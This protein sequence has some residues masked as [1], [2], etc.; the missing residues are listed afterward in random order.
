MNFFFKSLKGIS[1]LQNLIIFVRE[2]KIY[3]PRERGRQTDNSRVLRI[4]ANLPRTRI[5]QNSS[6]LIVIT[7]AR[8]QRVYNYNITN[9]TLARVITL[10]LPSRHI[11]IPKTI[12]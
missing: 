1:P 2:T 7:C 5:I 6:R 3:I 4:R 11:E 9:Y 8:E 10:E 12:K